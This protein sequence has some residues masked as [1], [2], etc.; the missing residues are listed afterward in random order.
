MRLL[1][2]QQAAQ[3]L[4]ISVFTL[5]DWLSQS[6]NGEF[7]IRGEKVS[8]AYYQ[9]GRRGQGRIRIDRKEVDRLLSAM[10][11]TPKAPRARRQSKAKTELQHITSK[12]G[13]PDD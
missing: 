10:R 6:K 8:I 11:V 13:R 4:G 7:E 12:L 5:Y 1:T 9:G 3:A 2:T